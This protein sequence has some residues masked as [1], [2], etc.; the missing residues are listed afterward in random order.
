MSRVI[1]LQAR[2]D[3]DA[4]QGDEPS[5]MRRLPYARRLELER[6]DA[7]SR[8]AG[9]VALGLALEGLARVRGR[10]VEVG[11]LHF[12]QG[13]KPRCAGGES[14]SISHS[15]RTAAVAVSG[16]CDVGIDVEDLGAPGDA[17]LDA[18]RELEHWTTVEAVLKAA[19]VGLR[20]VHEVQVDRADLRAR[21]RDREYFLCPLQL[22]PGIVAHLAATKPVESVEYALGFRPR[23]VRPWPWC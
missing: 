14:F 12:P 1:V 15:S 7:R 17:D 23:R 6:R 5:L 11:E 3:G 13:G 9:M 21:L 16:D 4:P 19:A 2:L 20:H 22:G 8:R 10:V 18:R